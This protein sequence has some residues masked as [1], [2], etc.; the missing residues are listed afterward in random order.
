MADRLE[1][2]QTAAPTL[3][4]VGWLPTFLYYFTGATLIAALSSAQAF[5][6]ELATG[7]PFRF[8]IIPGLLAGLAGAYFNRTVSLAIPCGT[9]KPNAVA[10]PKAF[11][12]QLNQALSDLG[13][14]PKSEL[15]GG[16]QVYQRSALR[17]WL[18]GSI[19]V[20]VA[21]GTATIFGRASNIK[22]LQKKLE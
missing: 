10:N 20:Q 13:Y 3:Q 15:E 22:R 19:L 14:T 8:G 5:N 12:T 18:S 17:H 1:V 6:L 7:E 16:Y 2:E 11:K 4:T 21:E 9:A